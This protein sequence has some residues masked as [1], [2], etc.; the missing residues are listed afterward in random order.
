MLRERLLLL[1]LCQLRRLLLRLLCRLL[2][3]L[4]QL[5]EEHVPTKAAAKQFRHE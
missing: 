1:S 3:L 5:R 4:L 2:L